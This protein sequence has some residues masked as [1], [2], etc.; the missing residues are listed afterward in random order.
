MFHWFHKHFYIR[1]YKDQKKLL[2]NFSIEFSHQSLREVFKCNLIFKSNVNN[3]NNKVEYFWMVQFFIAQ[4]SACTLLWFLV[5]QT[6]KLWQACLVSLW[7][8]HI[9][10]GQKCCYSFCLPCSVNAQESLLGKAYQSFSFSFLCSTQMF[11]FT[12][13]LNYYYNTD[14]LQINP[15]SCKRQVH[16]CFGFSW[17]CDIFHVRD[18]DFIFS[19]WFNVFAF[20]LYLLLCV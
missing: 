8:C 5:N 20:F 19:P 17:W 16:L 12:A 9:A 2:L 13:A 3:D 10:L 6:C 18:W 4:R 14:F 15:P 7:T 11:Y 1:K